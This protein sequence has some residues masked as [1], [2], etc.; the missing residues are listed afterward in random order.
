[1]VDDICA[2]NQQSVQGQLLQ[3]KTM[4]SLS[5]V[6]IAIL[7]LAYDVATN[8]SIT[9][10]VYILNGYLSVKTNRYGSNLNE[11]TI[12]VILNLCRIEVQKAIKTRGS[13]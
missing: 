6:E 7:G 8:Q 11:K 13:Q 2:M 4:F 3:M 12:A 1:M 5:K 9:D 10:L